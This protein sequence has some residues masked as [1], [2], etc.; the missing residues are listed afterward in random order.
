MSRVVLYTASDGSDAEVVN[1]HL[2][3][4]ENLRHS[5]AVYRASEDS[6]LFVKV[7]LSTWD[8]IFQIIEDFP[9]PIKALIMIHNI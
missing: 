1:Q 7:V 5:F 6:D 4:E 9:D 2:I 3:S 8:E